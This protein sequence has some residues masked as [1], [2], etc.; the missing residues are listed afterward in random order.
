MIDGYTDVAVVVSNAQEAKEWYVDKLGFKVVLDRGH[1]VCV[2]PNV[3]GDSLVLH[4][5]ADNFAPLESG[6]TEI[7]FT[8]DDFEKACEELSAK[9]VRFSMQPTN[10][11]DFKSAKFLDLNGNEFWL[12]E[13]R[14]AKKVMKENS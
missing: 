7:G 4:L 12:F 1:V 8:A 10:E 3:K 9:G 11:D 14:L 2:S 5:C 6:N 13:S